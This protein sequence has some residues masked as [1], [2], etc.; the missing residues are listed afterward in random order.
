[1]ST[2][3]KHKLLYQIALTQIKGVGDIIARNLLTIIG[4]EE[5]IFSSSR[6]EL[7][8]I[9]GL[10]VKVVD[11]I[12][13][14]EVL[15][16]AEKELLFVE[17][18]NIAPLFISEQ[19]YPSRLRECADAPIL[20]YYRGNGDLNAKKII[21][22]VGTRN[23]THY[24]IQFCESFLQDLANT[25]PEMLIVSGLAYGVDILAHRNALKNK[26]PTVGVLAHGLDRVYPSAHRSTAVDMMSNGGLLTEFTSNTEPDRFNFVRRNRIVAGISDAVIVVESDVKGG[27][28]ITAEIAN[29]YCKD[30]FAVPGKTLDAKSAGCNKLIASHKADLFYSTEHFLEQMGWS[31][32]ASSAKQ[33][34]VQ[35]NLFMD[36]N[37][38]EQAIVNILSQKGNLH[39]DSLAREANIPAFQLFSILLELEMK[40]LV[41]NMPGNILGLV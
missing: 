25:Y 14:P 3:T 22:I 41:K 32:E 16:R 40:S 39:I 26:L 18:H 35:R 37:S 6:K 11:E 10:P 34:P 33:Q 24:A 28:L 7:L 4:D 38:E 13:N 30:V 17:K 15:R 8:S 20:L 31:K 27:S 29:S 5:A 9:K 19:D 21:S 2:T 12:R 23:A 1:M 36:L